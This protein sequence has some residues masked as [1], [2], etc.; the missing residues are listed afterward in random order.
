M[1]LQVFM[2]ILNDNYNMD[3]TGFWQR[4][5]LLIKQRKTSQ[6]AL[7]VECGFIERRIE[8]LSNKQF[9]KTVETFKMAQSLKTTVE[10]LITGKPPEGID[11]EV[12]ETARQ[13]A[14]LPP[15]D[16]KEILFLIELKLKREDEALKKEA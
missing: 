9:P 1:N 10:Y 16:R 7:S 15:N 2:R 13:I 3:I 14:S 11:P 4:T 8:I 6:R 12:L 5:N